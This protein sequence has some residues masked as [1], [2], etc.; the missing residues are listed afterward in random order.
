MPTDDRVLTESVKFDEKS[1]FGQKFGD[2]FSDYF[3][4]F[5]VDESRNQN[6]V[7]NFSSARPGKPSRRR[8]R[9][10]PTGRTAG[11]TL[12]AKL[13]STTRLSF[14]REVRS[15]GR[16]PSPRWRCWPT[17]SCASS[18]VWGVRRLVLMNIKWYFRLRKKWKI[19][20]CGKFSYKRLRIGDTNGSVEKQ[21]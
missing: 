9:S 21:N 18:Q 12:A 7:Q 5:W 16:S 19:L 2:K 15:S 8:P 20:F 17:T 1:D 3:R 4:S 10:A 14:R 6:F 11:H 13:A